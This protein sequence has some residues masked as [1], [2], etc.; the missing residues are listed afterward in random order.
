VSRTPLL[1]QL[2]KV[3]SEQPLDPIVVENIEKLM[4]QHGLSYS[5]THFGFN[6]GSAAGQ[7][8]LANAHPAKWHLVTNPDVVFGARAIEQ[9]LTRSGDSS[10]GILE[11]RQLPL[12]LA[13]QYEPTTGDTS[14]ASGACSLIRGDL[15][16][17]LDGYDARTFFLY[18]D[19]VDL[20]WRVRLLGHRVV[21][22][23][24]SRVFHDKRPVREASAV[25]STERLYSAVG[26]YLLVHKWGTSEDQ[27]RVIGFISGDEYSDA[28]EEVARLRRENLLP[29]HVEHA[30]RVAQFA[31][32]GTVGNW[33]FSQ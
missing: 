26:S 16:R 18:G 13:K 20:S 21:H 15:W 27:E 17:V 31:I 32:D 5:Y 7:N 14:W 28:R 30:E 2:P 8:L 12:E 29:P 33:R 23:P 1:T 25:N 9:L 24:T 3:S 22:V 10:I 11:S 6:S 4:V 19:D